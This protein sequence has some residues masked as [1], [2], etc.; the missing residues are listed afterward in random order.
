[1]ISQTLADAFSGFS[2]DSMPA[3]SRAHAAR[4]YADTIACMVGGLCDAE[5]AR[6][7]RRF[8]GHGVTE[9]LTGLKAAYG[10]LALILGFAAAALELDDGHYETGSHPAAHAAAGAL[11]V[12]AQLKSDDKARF[13]AFLVGYEVGARVGLG[14]TLRP[15]AHGHGTWGAIGAAAA[16]AHLTGREPEDFAAILDIAGGLGL[17]TSVTAPMKGGTIRSAWVGVAARNGLLALDLHDAGVTGEP[18]GIEAVFGKVLGSAFD[19]DA[20]AAGLGETFLIDT[21]FMKLDAS[22]RETQ[23]AL[24]AFRAAWPAGHAASE[25]A[26]IEIATFDPAANLSEREPVNVMAGRFSIPA[27]VALAA[28]AKPITA[29]NYEAAVQSPMMREVMRRIEVVE[30]PDATDALPVRRCTARV[31][32]IDGTEYEATV[33]GAPG[34]ADQPL[35][36]ADLRAKFDALFAEAGRGDADAMYARL[37]ADA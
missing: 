34:D 32:L 23:G 29:A 30:D 27:T 18:G 7:A 21:N 19:A 9:P 36:P 1:M 4:V 6:F 35:S 24:A 33:D 10:N 12:A 37:T 13:E 16:A 17:G 31:H 3:S 14:T 5:V 22:C 11:A 8:S 28:G 20:A 26:W 25:I 15:D 2:A